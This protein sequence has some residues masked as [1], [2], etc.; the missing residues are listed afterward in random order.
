[1]TRAFTALLL[2][3]ALLSQTSVQ[4]QTA[5]RWLM[6]PGSLLEFDAT[7]QGA[8]FTGRFERF[9]ATV[10]AV[11]RYGFFVEIDSAFV[12]GLVPVARLDEYFEYV[13]ERTELASRSSGRRYRI[14]DRLAVTLTVAD[15]V[16]RRVEF[17]PSAPAPRRSSRRK[18]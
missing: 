15:L 13:A 3:G 7:Q 11:E 4:A 6:E 1:M 5:P 8:E 12:E 14:G 16:T 9:E 2:A 10:T 18:T 17:E